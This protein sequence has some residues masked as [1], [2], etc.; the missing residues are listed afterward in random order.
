[1]IASLKPLFVIVF[2]F[3]H[4]LLLTIGKIIK[5]S[6]NKKKGMYKFVFY[7]YIFN[8]EKLSQLQP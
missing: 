7:S 8:I 6:K 2:R 1:M 4:C 3:L 5:V